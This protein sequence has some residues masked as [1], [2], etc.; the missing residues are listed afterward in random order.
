MR[1]A[2]LRILMKDIVPRA[3]PL[4]LEPDGPAMRLRGQIY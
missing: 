3:T 2:D 1:S 4:E